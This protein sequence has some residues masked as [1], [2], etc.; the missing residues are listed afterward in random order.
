MRYSVIALIG[1]LLTL[2]G[3][4]FVLRR[5]RQARSA[6]TAARPPQLG[7]QAQLRK[8]R[9]DR[10]IW[11]VKVESHCHASSRIAGRQYALDAVPPLPVAGCEAATCS[12]CLI[13]LADRRDRSDRR[14]G[15]ERRLS[16]RMD[17]FERRS[18]QP[19]RR[20]DLNSWVNYGHL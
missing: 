8:L 11:G 7:P 4:Y 18:E 6:T 1:T 15:R 12:C 19:R 3:A 14:T 13:G 5:R 20:D 16:M 10:R 9:Q 17:T 2:F